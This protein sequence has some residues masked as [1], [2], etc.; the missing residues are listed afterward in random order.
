MNHQEIR[1]YNNLTSVM[2]S[3]SSVCYEPP[4]DKVIQHS[5]SVMKSF[6]SVCNEPPR[7]K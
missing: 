1:R 6:S 5:T 4:R 2:K 3:F 7:D